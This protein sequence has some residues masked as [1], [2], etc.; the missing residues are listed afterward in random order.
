MKR[1]IIPIKDKYLIRSLLRLDNMYEQLAYDNSPDLDEFEIDIKNSVWFMLT[2]DSYTS[3]LI[4]IDFL[5][6][7]LCTP[8]IYLFD[9]YRK[10]GS[11]EWGKQVATYM[12]EKFGVKKF[13]AFT[14]YENAKQYAER[15]GFKFKN[16]LTK[17]I[18]KD[19]KLL[20]QYV[21]ELGE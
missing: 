21:L 15:V 10:N 9:N 1:E 3:G 6:N 17:S 11:E 16:M 5:N 20:D 19:G 18:L 13:I 4:K 12:K 2:A 7:V 14:P 8:H